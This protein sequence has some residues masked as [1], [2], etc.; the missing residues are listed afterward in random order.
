MNDWP[1]ILP[2]IGF[3]TLGIIFFILVIWIPMFYRKKSSQNAP[4]VSLPAEIS[5]VYYNAY[6]SP[7]AVS[8]RVDGEKRPRK[9]DSRIPEITQFPE[10]GT[11]GTLTCKGS[12]LYSFRWNG[13]EV[14]QDAPGPDG[15]QTYSNL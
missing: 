2:I 5:K 1:L 3:C 4:I 9:F 12:I 15:A 6:G 14:V 11:R 10:P 13:G 8:F 7:P